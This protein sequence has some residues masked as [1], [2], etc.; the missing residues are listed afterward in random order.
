MSAEV[1]LCCFY[2]GISSA[3]LE[4]SLGTLGAQRGCL[5]PL[6]SPSL[7]SLPASGLLVGGGDNPG[8][9]QSPHVHCGGKE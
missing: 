5:H 1:A 6:C 2:A 3:V 4:P 8:P 7:P 9:T